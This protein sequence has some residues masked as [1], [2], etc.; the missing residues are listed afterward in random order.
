MARNEA[1]DGLWQVDILLMISLYF[2]ETSMLLGNH[3]CRRIHQLRR[4]Q[5]TL[6]GILAPILDLLLSKG[7]LHFVYALSTYAQGSPTSCI[8]P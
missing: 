2:L 1:H 3:R 7:L 8:L 6:L 4:M 5:P